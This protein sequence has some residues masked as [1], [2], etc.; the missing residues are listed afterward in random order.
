MDLI[1]DV[2]LGGDRNNKLIGEERSKKGKMWLP[3]GNTQDFM[4]NKK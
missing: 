1:S 4:E 3:E 2:K